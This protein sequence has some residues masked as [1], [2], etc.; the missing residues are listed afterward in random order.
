[1]IDFGPIRKW[2]NKMN[3]LMDLYADGESF[4]EEEK[5]LLL[6]YIRRIKKH[7]DALP[8]DDDALP[9]HVP[10]ASRVV[11]DEVVPKVEKPQPTVVVPEVKSEDIAPSKASQ[12]Q[13]A[14]VKSNPEPQILIPEIPNPVE[15][16]FNTYP[17][18]FDHLNISD[19]SQKLTLTPIKDIRVSMGLNEKIVVKNDLFRGDQNDMDAALQRLNQCNN[20]DEA[21]KFLCRDIIPKYNWDSPDKEHIV[22]KFVLTV[23]RRFL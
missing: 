15:E 16:N 22:D 2:M 9:A 19:L 5:D 17:S 14:S 3:Q 7:V 12:Q 10:N 11:S 4:T 20:F 8:V 23:Y 21:K 13:E 6:D 1:M 18:L